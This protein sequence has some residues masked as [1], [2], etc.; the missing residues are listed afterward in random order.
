MGRGWEGGKGGGGGMARGGK[1]K[2]NAP[3]TGRARK[4]ELPRQ[5]TMAKKLR[6]QT[7]GTKKD[8]TTKG[9]G[10]PGKNGFEHRRAFHK[11]CGVQNPRARVQLRKGK[12]EKKRGKGET[13]SNKNFVGGRAA[14]AGIATTNRTSRIGGY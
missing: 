1:K 7:A 8:A 4:N 12:K 5:R 13:G 6:L 2:G 9:V 11:R 14:H 3:P 10:V